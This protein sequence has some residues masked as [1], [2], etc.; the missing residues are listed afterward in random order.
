MK[1]TEAAAGPTADRYHHSSFPIE[2][3]KQ[4]ETELSGGLPLGCLV[5][6]AK[7]EDRLDLIRL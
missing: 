7:A 5:R 1:L 2:R 6:G 3:W 4:V